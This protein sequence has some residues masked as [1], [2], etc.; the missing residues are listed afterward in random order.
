L[1]LRVSKAQKGFKDLRERKDRQDRRAHKERH[2]LVQSEVKALLELRDPA[3]PKDLKVRRGH[4][5]CKALTE[6]KAHRDAKD[7]RALL[8][9]RAAQAQQVLL[10]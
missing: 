6:S 3:G 2:Q 4:K 5:G 10:D 7:R 9:L 8:E 1:A